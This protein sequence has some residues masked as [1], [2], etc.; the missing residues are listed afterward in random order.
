MGKN[1]P[2]SRERV[3]PRQRLARNLRV[4]AK[5]A[6]LSGN[7]I[8]KK[9]G[10]DPKT[11]NEMLKASFDPRLSKVEK[12]AN[13]FGLSAWQLLAYDLEE[14]PPDSAN[15]VR[16]LEHYSSAPDDGRKAIMQV[17]EIAAAKSG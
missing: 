5:R 3:P 1:F 9:A 6:E 12:I 14:R 13:V 4:L 10:V 15:V 8:G 7:E 2:M 17:A 16:L 11:V